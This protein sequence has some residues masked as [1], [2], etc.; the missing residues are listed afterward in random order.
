MT[1][2]AIRK[3]KQTQDKMIRRERSSLSHTR[4]NKMKQLI[5]KEVS[6]AI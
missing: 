2:E 4:Y 5:L 6:D 3:Y 1:Q